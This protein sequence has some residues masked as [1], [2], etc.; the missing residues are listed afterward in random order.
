MF[1]TPGLV[2]AWSNTWI[3]IQ[4][5]RTSEGVASIYVNNALQVSGSTAIYGGGANITTMG[6]GCAVVGYY[7]IRGY[8]DEVYIYN[9]VL[10]D[11]DRRRLRSGLA[12]LH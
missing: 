3:N 8:I 11:T 2:A 10:D 4:A 1:K 12:A 9:K 5:T 6:V 7:G